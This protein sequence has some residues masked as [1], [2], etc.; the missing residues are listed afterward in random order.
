MKKLV[1]ISLIFATVCSA[2]KFNAEMLMQKVE[3]ADSNELIAIV[4]QGKKDSDRLDS[5][6]LIILSMASLKSPVGWALP[7]TMRKIVKI[8]VDGQSPSYSTIKREPTRTQK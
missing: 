3:S 2:E 4:E 5:Y 6:S 7:I 8:V 1:L